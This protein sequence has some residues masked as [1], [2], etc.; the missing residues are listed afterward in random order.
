MTEKQVQQ[1]I[2]FIELLFEQSMPKQSF[3]GTVTVVDKDNDTCKV[4]REAA[5]DL[6]DVRLLS[7][8]DDIADKIVVYPK[9]GS[10]VICSVIE[11]D[12]KE[13]WISAHSSIES[14]LVVMGSTSITLVDGGVNIEVGASKCKIVDGEITYNDGENGGLTI[15]P[16]L[17]SELNKNNIILQSLMA[18]INGAPVPEPGAGSPSAL[19]TALKG[20]I[21]GK[22]VGDFSQVENAKI[23]H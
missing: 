11:N 7:V 16:A 12:K 1:F 19:Q 13:T 6:I 8:V 10:K 20:A 14:I 23:K 2:R 18:V 21:A 9:E 4:S 15:T 22:A 17:V 5:P 3:V